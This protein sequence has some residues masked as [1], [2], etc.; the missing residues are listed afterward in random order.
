MLKLGRLADSR[1]ELHNVTLRISEYKWRMFD[2]LVKILT[3]FMFRF[4]IK[5]ACQ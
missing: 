4:S 2:L 1:A 3:P 5:A